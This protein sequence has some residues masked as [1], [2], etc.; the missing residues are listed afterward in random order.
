MGEGIT[1]GRAAFFQTTAEAFLADEALGHEV[2]GASSIL[3]RCRD[4]AD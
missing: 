1:A 2:F 4:E 3:V